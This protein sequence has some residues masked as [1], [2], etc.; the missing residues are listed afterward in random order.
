MIFERIVARTIAAIGTFDDVTVDRRA[1]RLWQGHAEVTVNT[2][3]G[4]D[5][6]ADQIH[7][8]HMADRRRQAGVISGIH[9]VPRAGQPTGAFVAA[10]LFR[11]QRTREGAA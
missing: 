11:V 3:H 10:N 4:G 6:I 1:S 9:H 5:R 2:L 7:V 8:V